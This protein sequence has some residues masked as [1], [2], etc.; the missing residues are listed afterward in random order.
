MGL[1]AFA[2]PPHWIAFYDIWLGVCDDARHETLWSRRDGVFTAFCIL[3]SS[4][5]RIKHFLRLNYWEIRRMQNELAS[6][7]TKIIRKISDVVA[8]IYRQLCWKFSCFYS[9]FIRF[10]LPFRQLVSNVNDPGEYFLRRAPIKIPKFIRFLLIFSSLTHSSKLAKC[11]RVWQV[12]AT[13]FF[14]SLLDNLLDFKF[15]LK[16]CLR[17]CGGINENRRQSSPAAR[18]KKKEK[19]T[20]IY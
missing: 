9:T 17:T 2:F 8:M 10:L 4:R 3:R 1:L 7:K 12:A 5:E 14:C 13:A 20:K 11:L 16:L 19:N 15:I 18:V 6:W